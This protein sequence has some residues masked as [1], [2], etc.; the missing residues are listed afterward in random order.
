MF[1]FFKKKE[2]SLRDHLRQ[3]KK[4]KIDG[5]IF[6]IKK[7]NIE[8]HLTGLDVI[9]NFYSIYKE[10]KADPSKF[11]Q[12]YKKIRKVMRDLIYAGVVRPEL[13]MKADEKNKIHIEEVL[14]EHQLAQKL[15][16]RIIEYSYG[17]KK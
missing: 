9:F 1:G 15:T 16:S 2:I 17:K 14:N 8:D 5:I 6:R 13:T 4:I 11:P 3:E 7:I 10:N 12:E